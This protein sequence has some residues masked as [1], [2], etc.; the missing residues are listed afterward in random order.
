MLSRFLLLALLLITSCTGKPLLPGFNSRQWQADTAGCQGYRAGLAKELI[1]RKNELAGSSQ[2]DITA[3]LGKPDR[4][5]LYSRN[6]KAFVYFINGGPGCN[7]TR[8]NPDKLVIRF[9]GIG[10][11]KE[12]ILY[13]Q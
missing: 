2:N 1:N 9:D 5:E 10:R 8:E 7:P 3:L 13:Q 11:A 6:K 4:H 12:V